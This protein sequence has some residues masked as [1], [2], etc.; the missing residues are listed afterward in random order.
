M[1][2][3]LTLIGATTAALLLTSL[4]AVAKK[5]LIVAA[6]NSEVF[7]GYARKKLPDGS[8]K[9][10]YYAIAD[11][12][13][14]SGAIRDPSIDKV[15]FPVLAGKIAEFL[16]LRNYYFAPNAK[17]ANLLMVISWGLTNPSFN[18]SPY[19]DTVNGVSNAMNTYKSAAAAAVGTPRSMDGI[20]SPQSAIAN[21]DREAFIS[22]LY[23]L[24]LYNKIRRRADLK[25]A[26]LLGYLKT[27]NRLSGISRLAGAGTDYDDLIADIEEPRYYVILKAFDFRAATQHHKVKLLWVTRVSIRAQGNQ[28]DKDMETM[29]ANASQY[30]GRDSYGLHRRFGNPSVEVGKLK[31]IG[32]EA[33]DTTPKQAK[34]KD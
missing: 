7:N 10:E 11:G 16:A 5:R 18:R 14:S 13:F 32:V 24:Q 8:F 25:D 26:R 34:G 20:E 19:D 33:M 27:I 22:Q 12:G 17:S 3:S 9:R 6:V 28:F 30:F 15:K 1:K 23:Q 31:F 21:A 2:S 4:P 29:L